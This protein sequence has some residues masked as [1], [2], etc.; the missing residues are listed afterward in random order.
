MIKNS[1][2][3]DNVSEVK[4]KKIHLN[5]SVNSVLLMKNSG[6]KVKNLSENSKKEIKSYDYSFE[7]KKGVRFS[8]T[9]VKKHD[10]EMPCFLIGSP[11]NLQSN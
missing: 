6:E 9:V 2:K 5:L 8:S 4:T 1:I 3:S 11:C 10:L 7:R